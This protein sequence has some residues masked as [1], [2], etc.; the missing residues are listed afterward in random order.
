LSVQQQQQ[1]VTVTHDKNIINRNESPKHPLED[2]MLPI[3]QTISLSMSFLF[4]EL[5]PN[6]FIA[7]APSLFDKPGKL[8]YYFASHF[9]SF[10]VPPFCR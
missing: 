9:S 10:V 6:P 3:L 7:S 8:C 2:A 5:L 1:N 4:Y